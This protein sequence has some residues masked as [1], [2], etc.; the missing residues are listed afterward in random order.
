[1]T[2]AGLSTPVKP[3]FPKDREAS[4]ACAAD[5]TATATDAMT[6]TSVVSVAAEAGRAREATMAPEMTIAAEALVAGL[7]EREITD[8][9]DVWLDWPG[10]RRRPKL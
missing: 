9:R 1:L 5:G 6:L 3:M 10:A 8:N 4:G 2:G 7:T